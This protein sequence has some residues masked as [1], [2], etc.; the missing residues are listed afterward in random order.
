MG[1]LLVYIILL[2]TIST[3]FGQCPT[4]PITLTTQAEVNAFAINYPNCTEL[5]NN[6]VID[7]DD[8]IDLSS[9][10][11]ITSI[12]EDLIIKNCPLLE[13]LNGLGNISTLKNLIIQD[14]II[15]P[16]LF[17]LEGI[18]V[19]YESFVVDGNFNLVTTAG[20]ENVWFPHTRFEV[21]GSI[22]SFENLFAPNSIL[23]E[24]LIRH[25]DISNFEGFENVSKIEGNIEILQNSN[26]ENFIGLENTIIEPY[27]L[28]IKSNSISTF[29]G[30]SNVECTP[31]HTIEISYNDMLNSLDGLFIDGS[32]MLNLRITN[33]DVLENIDALEYV[34]YIV[35]Y[36]GILW[37]PDLSNCSVLSICNLLTNGIG[38]YNFN[39]NAI[40][41]N[42]R[43]EVENGCNYNYNA[44]QGNIYYD[45]D[46][47]N[48]TNE[49]YDVSNILITL[50]S[51]N[52]LY[53]FIPDE[54]GRYVGFTGEEGIHT[55]YV[56]TASL[57][58][59]YTA[60]PESVEIDFEGLGNLAEAD[61]CLTATE[62]FNNL[63]ITVIPINE[64][65]PGLDSH[66]QIIY[67]NVGT[68]VLS[69][70]LSLQFD[71]VRQQFIGAT[72]SE[73]SISGNSI[74]WNY[75]DLLPFQ[76][77]TIDVSFN[78]FPP[79]INESGDILIFTATINPIVDDINPEDN[80]YILEQ[81][82]VNSQDP[83]DKIVNQGAEIYEA[84]VG[85]Y[86]DYIVRFQNVGTASAINVRVEDM[87]SNNLDWNTFR[88]LSASHE[89][90]VEIKEGNE[91]DFVF[92]DINLPSVND[93]PEG[94][95]GF[96]AFQLKSKSTLQVGDTIENEA[97][98]YFD[99]NAPIL[100]NTVVTEIVENLGSFETVIE[101]SVKFIPNPVSEKLMVNISENIQLNNVII[102][103]IEGKKLSETSERIIDFSKFS[104]GVYFINVETNNGTV[105]KKIVKQ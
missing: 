77:R 13:S 81:E 85:E 78:N 74:I 84:E 93:D 7:G 90:R 58:L 104:E 32:A 28:Y 24:V 94:S 35:N 42:S 21:I 39:N 86:L 69:G 48:C 98:I 43:T 100:T 66:Y 26:L 60:N 64:A 22:Q 56:N 82:M 18:S 79:P 17:G 16:N 96:I 27:T 31:C 5:Y 36:L 12:D 53:Y 87:L 6:L 103:S 47:N 1:K 101:N 19:I 62:I 4:T 70:D 88:I 59:N 30:L 37:N 51:T 102:Y 83:N 92:E 72:P 75:E 99:F 55:C 52:T 80:E 25:T 3:S 23:S 89:Y 57:P 15:L 67:E 2:A 11:I 45:F 8:I 34:P 29:E 54:N 41:C 10:T 61:F 49:D 46:N 91:V 40:G 9:L 65:R 97:N 95:N 50:E 105:T 63:K 44:V 68:T 71:D 38:L 14:N 33:N 73:T 20:L 76:S